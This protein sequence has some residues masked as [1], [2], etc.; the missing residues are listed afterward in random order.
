LPFEKIL[1]EPSHSPCADPN[2]LREFTLR[3]VSVQS[4]ALL[5]GECFDRLKAIHLLKL[6]HSVLSSGMSLPDTR[7]SAKGMEI[8]LFKLG[9]IIEERLNERLAPSVALFD[10][11]RRHAEL[12]RGSL[13]GGFEWIVHG[14]TCQPIAI[15][16]DA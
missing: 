3:Y 6:H 8:R 13:L 2:R 16:V 1:L 14:F 5:A 11:S 9:R 12:V 10:N 4:A 7:L 15:F